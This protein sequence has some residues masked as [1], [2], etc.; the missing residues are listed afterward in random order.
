LLVILEPGVTVGLTLTAKIIEP[1]SPAFRLPIVKTHVVPEVPP[2]GQ[3]QPGVVEFTASK[4]VLAGTI[5]LII[6]PVA[7]TLPILE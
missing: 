6:T 1:E 7:F 3:F 5:S 2:S 4:L